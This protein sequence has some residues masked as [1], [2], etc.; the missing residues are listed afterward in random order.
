MTRPRVVGR[1][2]GVTGGELVLRTDGAA[3]EVIA[4]G[5]FLMDTRDG[6]S[7]R[8]L[9][10]L[11]LARVD[12]PAHVVLG[13]LGLGT[14][15]L[16]AV[17]DRRVGRITVLEHEPTLVAWHEEHLG[18]L[19]GPALSDPRVH[20]EVGDALAWLDR[21]EPASV[22]VLCL[23]IDNGPDWLVTPANARLYTDAGT[24]ACT[25]VLTTGGALAHWSAAPS[26]GLVATMARHLDD[27]VEHTFAH[28]R[29]EPDVVVVG[30]MP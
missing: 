25:R 23:D 6:R 16:T 18:T 19:T 17:A 2:V 26:P 22:Q 28:G 20:V 13:G 14:S 8:A 10:T 11:A 21:R 5:V 7:E 30:H 9:V 29:G 1:A 15:L 3:W 12:D 24:A 27:V 4:N